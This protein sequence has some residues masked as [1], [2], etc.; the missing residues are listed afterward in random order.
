LE[1][2]GVLNERDMD[3]LLVRADGSP[4]YLQ[5]SVGELEKVIPKARHVRL[6]RVD[7]SVFKNMDQG[8]RSVLVVDELK[9]FL[10]GDSN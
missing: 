6:K 1:G 3:V 4:A 2:A 5:E 9:R 7:P 8:G 10:V